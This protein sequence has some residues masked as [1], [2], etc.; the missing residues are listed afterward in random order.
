MAGE[1]AFASVL[2]FVGYIL[3]GEIFGQ[4]AELVKL[5]NKKTLIFTK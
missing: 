5:I 3:V 1:V 2:M 4:M